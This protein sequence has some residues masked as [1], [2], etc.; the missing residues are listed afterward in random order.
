MTTTPRELAD[1]L[2]VSAKTIRAFLREEYPDHEHRARW[3]LED[4]Q[5]TLVRARFSD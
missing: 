5:E 3:E 4:E 1:Q 2:D